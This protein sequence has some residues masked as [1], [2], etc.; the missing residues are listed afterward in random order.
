M[1]YKFNNRFT[2]SYYAALS[3]YTIWV[4]SAPKAAVG[5]VVFGAEIENSLF[6]Y[7]KGLTLFIV[8]I[9]TYIYK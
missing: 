4:I 8:I 3:L 6:G 1:T 2:N 5:Q 7:F 9:R